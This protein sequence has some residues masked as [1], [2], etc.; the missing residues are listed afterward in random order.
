VIDAAA[1]ERESWLVQEDAFLASLLD[2]H[3]QKLF[4][5]ERAHER[6]LADMDLAFD[7][8]QRE[9]ENARTDVMRL[10][11]ERDAAVALLNEPF[12]ST[13]R[14]PR[15]VGDLGSVKLPK[16]ILKPKPEI[17]SRPIVG[18]SLVSEDLEDERLS[19]T[20]TSRPPRP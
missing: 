6:K 17:A 8:L 5:L 10:T 15:P 2:E 4:E 1:H 16:P 18:Y 13:E 3:E 7:E 11:Y 9:R 19:N 20:P 12:A 14:T